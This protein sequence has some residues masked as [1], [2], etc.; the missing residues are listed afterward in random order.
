MRE[1]RWPG[2]LSATAIV[3]VFVL[4]TI[5]FTYPQ[6]TVLGS[7]P[8]HNDP[9]FST[10]RLAWVA[11]QLRTA[12]AQIFDANILYPAQG[13]LLY[14]D[15][16]LLL[17]LFAAPLIWSGVPVI[18]AYNIL[19]LVSFVFAGLAAFVFIRYLTA[20]TLAAVIGGLIY[21]FSPYRFGHY[22]HQELLWNGWIPLALWGLHRTIDTGRWRPALVT[23]LCLV[24]QMYSS[25]YYGIFLATFMAIVSIALLALRVIAWR[26]PALK[27]LIAAAALSGVLIAP[28]LFV[29]A[30]SAAIVGERQE[31]E[32]AYFS[33]EAMDYL[34]APK[35]N[36]LYGWTSGRWTA[37]EGDEMHL[38]P[39]LCAVVL[40]AIGLWPPISRVR[41]AYAVALVLAIDLS[42]GFNGISYR[43]LF[44]LTPLFRG[45]RAT[46][47]FATFVQL[48]IALF[49]ACGV[50]RLLERALARRALAALLV[51]GVSGVLVLEY[52]NRSIP[53]VHLATRPSLLSQWLRQQ[54]PTVVLELP[55]ARLSA[56][57]GSDPHYQFE[58][59]F[60][61]HQL[62]N[63]Y[64][65]FV[66]PRY[67]KFLE[68]MDAF[69]DER[70]AGALR[71]SGAELF[72]V[73][74]QWFSRETT[75]HVTL[76]W[77]QRQPDF[78]FEGAFAD[79]AGSVLVFRRV[80]SAS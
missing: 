77:F 24:A 64:T 11:H 57:P 25:I 76:E 71:A 41:V 63:G 45:L 12:P 2:W 80:R 43:L 73:H 42:L 22:M 46:A 26:G 19:I 79:H 72:I 20:S 29:Y 54:K 75:P 65:S 78:R 52:T 23:A 8:P 14:S 35:I 32:A 31:S 27:H 56:L 69:P 33:A 67:A 7:A 61:W 5:W 53:L 17:G 40:A 10:W 51:A 70:S 36:W 39:G 50:A 4:A 74:P 37:R 30:K 58:S 44:A 15:A 55:V 6:I 28:Y 60:H 13:T 3:L 68:R 16:F 62:V 34:A 21:A 66:P 48:T 49:A 18:V 1:P 38:F 9:L 59:T 47:R